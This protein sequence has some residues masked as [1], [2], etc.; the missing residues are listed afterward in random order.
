MQVNKPTLH[1]ALR[2]ALAPKARSYK[3]QIPDYLPPSP[4]GFGHDLR[5]STHHHDPIFTPIFT[6][7]L[8]SGVIFGTTVTWASLA[9]AITVTNVT[10]GVQR[11]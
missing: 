4:M 1:D 6:Y 9:S 3:V 7:I 11:R 5:S 2:R 10:K 8:G